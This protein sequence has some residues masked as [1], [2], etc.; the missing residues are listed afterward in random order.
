MQGKREQWVEHVAAWAS[1]GRSQAAWCREHGVSLASFGYW[2]RKLAQDSAAALPATL[3][4]RVT[5][6]RQAPTTQVRLPSGVIV[7]VPAADPAWLASL[8]RAL[9]AC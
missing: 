9:G 7:S 1:S 4:I 5:A 8:L 6:A 3:P 2:R